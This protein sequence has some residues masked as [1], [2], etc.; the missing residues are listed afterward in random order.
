[1]AMERMAPI[2]PEVHINRKTV[3]ETM[4]EDLILLNVIAAVEFAPT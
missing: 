3:L 2:F 1:M 4:P